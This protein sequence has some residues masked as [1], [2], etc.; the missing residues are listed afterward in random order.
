MID[1][2]TPIVRVAPDR[3]INT[4][5]VPASV[6]ACSVTYRMSFTLKGLSATDGG[7]C[8]RRQRRRS[9]RSNH[10][11]GTALRDRDVGASRNVCVKRPVVNVHLLLKLG[12]HLGWC[13]RERF[14]DSGQS[15]RVELLNNVNNRLK[16]LNCQLLWLTDKLS[17]CLLDYR[18][19][20]LFD[21]LG[22]QTRSVRRRRRL[23]SCGRF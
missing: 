7:W 11:D 20:D 5:P 1:I 14:S 10:D 22:A 6:H 13:F 9:R 3:V 2:H 19:V 18:V 23:Y 17:D 4:S 15:F 12:L 8:E 21:L 16:L